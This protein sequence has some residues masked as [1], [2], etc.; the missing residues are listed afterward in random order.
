MSTQLYIP[1]SEDLDELGFDRTLH[2]LEIE[3]YLHI[4]YFWQEER[5]EF[6]QKFVDKDTLRMISIR[7]YPRSR[8]H[9]KQIIQ[10]FSPPQ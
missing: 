10:A 9:L 6:W 1:T 7:I 3:K 5:N 4:V 2:F 8:E